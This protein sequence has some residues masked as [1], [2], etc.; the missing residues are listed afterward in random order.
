MKYLDEEN[1]PIYMSIEEKVDCLEKLT[2]R[3]ARKLQKETDSNRSILKRLKD[4]ESHLS[5]SANLYQREEDEFFY[6]SEV[7]D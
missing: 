5:Q 6:F 2:I 7:S 3:I 4:V 1:N